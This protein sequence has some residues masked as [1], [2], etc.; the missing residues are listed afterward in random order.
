MK[1]NL[2]TAIKKRMEKE[3]RE[4]H[5]GVRGSCKVADCPNDAIALDMCNA[6]YIRYKKNRPID[7]P[8]QSSKTVC[9]ECGEKTGSKG[10]WG[11]CQKHFKIARQKSIK[12]ALVEALG[13]C[14]QKCGEVFPLAV[15]DFHH[16]SGEK[17][18]NPSEIIG[19]GSLESIAKEI[20][21]C[22]LLCANCHRIEHA[23]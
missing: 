11:R 1:S 14:C 7:T 9:I 23:K 2:I 21:K 6:H 19:N 22:T 17:E 10:G 12:E 5:N 3:V 20:S 16:H 18:A 8:I 4:L 15:Y 13:G